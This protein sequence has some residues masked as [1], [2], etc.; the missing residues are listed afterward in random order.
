MTPRAAAA[1]GKASARWRAGVRRDWNRSARGWERFEAPYLHAL[2]A[3]DPALYRALRLAPGQR[4]LDVGCGSGDPAIA[5]AQLVAPR[6]SVLGIDLAPGMLAIARR[7]ARL[8]G[9]TNLRFRTGDLS[10]LAVRRRF[11]RL[12]SRFS[13]MFVEDVAAALAGMRAALAPGGRIAIA[14]WGPRARNAI[15]DL[16]EQ[17]S[18]PFTSEPP[19][20][21]ERS[22]HPLRLARPGLI[23]RL[24]REAGFRRVA[25]EGVR[26]PLVYSSVDEALAMNFE[27]RG[28]LRTLAGKLP[29]RDRARLRARLARAVVRYRSGSVLR[30]PAFAWVASAVR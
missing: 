16:R 19:E 7:R 3:V 4:V 17:V 9:V 12:V 28:P 10:R 23:G 1:R 18:R 14:V 11:D 25:V 6:G 26:A 20:D 5:I 27:V 13:L 15:F 24:L 29:P 2:S 8:R 30:V 21:P 22:A